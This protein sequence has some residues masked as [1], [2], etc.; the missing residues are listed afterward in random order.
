[1]KYLEICKLIDD[2]FS[3]T[4]KNTILDSW[5]TQKE[6]FESILGI[7]NSD[8]KQ[9]LDFL[10]KSSKQARL[11]YFLF[12]KKEIYAERYYIFSEI[13]GNLRDC[14]LCKLNDLEIFKKV[15][16]Y[17]AKNYVHQ[18]WELDDSSSKEKLLLQS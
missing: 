6:T 3:I 12:D 15:I 7:K 10:E 14:D 18:T 2:V 1:M 9:I 4:T 5:K 13:R 17:F 8:N 16:E 11:E